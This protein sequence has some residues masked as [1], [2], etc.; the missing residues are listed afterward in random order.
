MID[1]LKEERIKILELL[2]EGKI[3][4]EDAEKLLTALAGD[5]KKAEG[6]VKKEKKAPFKMLRIFV[7]SKDGDR[8][9]VNIPIEFSKLL[10]SGKFGN[11]NFDNVDLDIDQILEMINSGA[12]GE[13]VTVDSASGDKVIITVE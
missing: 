7:D 2:Q 9:R 13:I 1:Q 11:F 10:K 12:E 8:V 3:T 5:E 6:F 4:P